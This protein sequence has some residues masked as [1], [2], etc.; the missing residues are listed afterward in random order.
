MSTLAP[1]SSDRIRELFRGNELRHTRQREL[2]YSALSSSKLH[3]TA[4]DLFH[5]VRI[6]DA[7]L[8]LATVYNTLEA[9]CTAGLARRVPAGSGPCRF[10]ADMRE[11]AHL[12]CADGG[13]S[14]LPEDLSRQLLAAISP[15][16]LAE[17]AHRLGVVVERVN[18]Q[19]HAHQE[20]AEERAN[21]AHP[22]NLTSAQPTG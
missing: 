10:D 22:H 19:V 1:S 14:D 17:I 20:S 2:V 16:A 3:P 9:F 4:E 21:S 8:S 13:V 6:A 18:V 11:H 15:G 7:E 12:V 5:Q